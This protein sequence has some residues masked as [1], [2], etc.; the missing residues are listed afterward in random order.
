MGWLASLENGVKAGW[1]ASLEDG[2]TQA[3]C[4]LACVFGKRCEAG[5]VRV[6]LRLCAK[7]EGA[8]EGKKC[9]CSF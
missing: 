6:S 8:R 4:G 1:L 3:L 2:V 5:T 7:E 9:A